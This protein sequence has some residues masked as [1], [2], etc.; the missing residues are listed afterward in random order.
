MRTRSIDPITFKPQR[1]RTIVPTHLPLQRAWRWCV[2][3]TLR[4]GQ[5]SHRQDRPIPTSC[6]RRLIY[7]RWANLCWA[8]N[9][10]PDN[11]HAITGRQT[12]WQ[13]L[14][15]KMPHS[16]KQVNPQIR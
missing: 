13:N 3:A 10:Q 16:G 9:I 1:P 5:L 8:K 11:P 14:Q 15:A 12:G 7:R 6:L 4:D 2:L